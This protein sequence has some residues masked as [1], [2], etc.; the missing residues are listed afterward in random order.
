MIATRTRSAVLANALGYQLVWFACVLGAAAGQAWPGVLASLLFTAATLAFGGC[1]RR[2]V[3]TLLILV[4]LGLAL[5]SVFTAVGWT[6]YSLPG[7]WPQIA[8]IW[9]AAIWLSFGMTLNH[10]LSFL[11]QRPWLAGLLGLIGAPLA[12]WS[13]A[14]GFGVIH[15]SQ[16]ALAILLALAFCWSLLLPLVFGLDSELRQRLQVP[17]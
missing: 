16:P 1:P 3:G 9:I 11:R 2:D 13:A 10:S 12:Y 17:A 4:P 5:D 14:R 8:P 6:R 15:F 7:P